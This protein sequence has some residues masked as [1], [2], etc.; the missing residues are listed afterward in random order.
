MRIYLEILEKLS[1]EESLERQPQQ[2]VKEVSSREEA[3]KLYNQIKPIFSGIS[4][5]ARIHYHKHSREG[6]EQCQIEVIE[7]T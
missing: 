5:V 7:E 3:I 4:Y 6:N 1:E 2:F